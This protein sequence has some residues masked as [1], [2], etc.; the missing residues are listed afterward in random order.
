MRIGSRCQRWQF[1]FVS[2]VRL[3]NLSVFQFPYPKVGP[4]KLGDENRTYRI[5]Y[6]AKLNSKYMN[7]DIDVL[8]VIIIIIRFLLQYSWSSECFT[9]VAGIIVI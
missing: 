6:K 9:E 8:P 4:S 2:L 3:L 1:L 7:I 5:S